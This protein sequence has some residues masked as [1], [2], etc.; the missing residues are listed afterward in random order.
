MTQAGRCAVIIDSIG[1]ASPGKA[2]AIARGLN[3]AVDETI[4]AIYRAPAVLAPAVNDQVA[5]GLCGVLRELGFK[6]SIAQADELPTPA[7][8]PLFDAALHIGDALATPAIAEIVADF[9]GIASDAALKLVTEPPAIVLGGVSAATIAALELRL[10]PYDVAVIASEPAVARF[11][12]F[13]AG[14]P[15]TVAARLR[16]ELEQ[17]GHAVPPGAGL[18][19][20]IVATGLE[21]GFAD[22]LWRKY[23]R[24]GT[25]RIVDQ[26]FLRF[27]LVLDGLEPGA[28]R[29]PA[30]A[31]ALN[32]L[33]G[34][35][36]DLFPDLLAAAPATLASDLRYGEFDAPLA[37]LAQCGL[38]ARAVLATFRPVALEI[39]AASDA[40]AVAREMAAL[41]LLDRAV[42]LPLVTPPMSAPL[43]RLAR[44]R[45]EAAG[46]EVWIAGVAA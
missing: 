35:P 1:T 40:E 23:G 33:F 15:A 10:A 30:Q 19:G 12:L 31:E 11:D 36:T 18:G 32:A 24:S 44:A 5:E 25:V 43:A 28:A 22:G 7:V 20:G 42:T 38:S 27:D 41:G 34:I 26:A 37:R 9:C 21:R 17:A 14:L 29:D 13:A 16:R 4:R 46:A 3:L 39:A 8:Q 45:L 6:A 2:I